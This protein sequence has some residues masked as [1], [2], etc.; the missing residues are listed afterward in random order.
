MRIILTETE[1]EDFVSILEGPPRQC[2]RL[3]KLL[4][5]ESPFVE[6]FDLTEE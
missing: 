5:E 2:P 3:I 1:Y 6:E 4:S